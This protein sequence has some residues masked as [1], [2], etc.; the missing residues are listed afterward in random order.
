MSQI[1]FG[2]N[3]V[4]EAFSSR[5]SIEKV[6]ILATL[7]GE[8][9]IKIRKLCK[10]HNIPLAKVPE[11]KL[12]DLTKK[13]LHQGV[14][15][16]ISPVQYIKFEDLLQKAV[17]ENGFL[18]VLDNV[19]DVRNMGAIARS[20]YYFGASGLVIAGNFSGQINED[21]VKTS[22]GAILN[23][24][25]ARTG[26]V[27]TAVAELQNKGFLV[28]AADVKGKKI[29]EEIDFTTPTALIMGAEEKGLH[30]KVLETADETVRIEGKGEFDS[31]NVSVASGVLLY[32]IVSQRK[33]V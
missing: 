14:A 18:I 8:L 10:E 33:R 20:G 2:K 17:A 25:I 29:P 16:V 6:Y 31:L 1:I 30:Y 9:E 24:P 32:E 3:P 26:S 19:S 11:V 5:Q 28:V 27:L 15:A 23:L 13:K 4:L 12:D 22:A 7:S 21:T